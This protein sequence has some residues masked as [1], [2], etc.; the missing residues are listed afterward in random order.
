MTKLI[1]RLL[2]ALTLAFA[3]I[4]LLGFCLLTAFFTT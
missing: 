4:V 3:V 2:I 1:L